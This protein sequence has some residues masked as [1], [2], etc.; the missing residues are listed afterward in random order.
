MPIFSKLKNFLPVYII[1]IKIS[2]W[3]S[4]KKI[5][6]WYKGPHDWFHHWKEK[7]WCFSW[8][9]KAFERLSKPCIANLKN[10]TCHFMCGRT[11]SRE[12]VKTGSSY[13]WVPQGYVLLYSLYIFKN[14]IIWYNILITQVIVRAESILLLKQNV[15]H[16]LKW[17]ETN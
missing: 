7:L 8:P 11:H 17:D 2:V 3:I 13:V 16:I 1:F 6:N 9:T 14:I 4:N 12:G 5:H 10:W 15:K